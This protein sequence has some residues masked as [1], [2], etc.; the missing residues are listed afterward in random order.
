MST[1]FAKPSLKGM[2]PFNR[3]GL[4]APNSAELIAMGIKQN[5]FFHIKYYTE[6]WVAL[7][8]NG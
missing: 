7:W 8:P 2:S 4:K 6:V 3:K 1:L 5:H